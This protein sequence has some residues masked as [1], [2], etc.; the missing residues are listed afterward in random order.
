VFRRWNLWPLYPVVRTL[1]NYNFARRTI[2]SSQEGPALG[3]YRE[4]FIG[5]ASEM[6]DIPSAAYDFVL[7]SHVLEHMANPLKALH[8]WARVVRPG[9]MI[10]L[11]APHHDGTFDHRRPLTTMD[12]IVSDFHGDVTERDETHVQEILNLHDLRL[13]PGAGTADAFVARAR[14]NLEHRSLHHHVFDTEL[15]LKLA[16]KADLRILY[17]DVELPFHI[18]VA[19]SS[20]VT[21][22]ER[23]G[24]D[25]PPNPSYW[26]PGAAWRR[27]TPFRSDRRSGE[28]WGFL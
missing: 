5:E 14:N 9:G 12:H 23:E 13:D 20:P 7:A 27:R 25:M 2:W 1:D 24:D 17:V 6:T 11:V 16:D 3:L 21:D 8:S 10:V 15:V 22:V 28:G 4:Q 18:C 19:C 26:A